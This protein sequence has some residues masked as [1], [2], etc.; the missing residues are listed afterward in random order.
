MANLYR[1]KALALEYM[2]L[3]EA[4][5]KDFKT[6][7]SYAK[8]IKDSNIR[9]YTLSL[10]YNNMTIYFLNKRL[11]NTTYKDSVIAYSKK[12]SR[13]LSLLMATVRRFPLQKNMRCFNLVICA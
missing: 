3:D 5:L 2:G 9:N 11:E 10:S 12:V 1:S 8:K 4:S 6:A 13:Q 7:V